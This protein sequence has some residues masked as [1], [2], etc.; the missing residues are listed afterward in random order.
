MSNEA[1]DSPLIS[2]VVPVKDEEGAVD[3]FLDHVLEE[4]SQIRRKHGS[5]FELIFVDDGSTDHTCDQVIRRRATSSSVPI[6]IISFSRNFGKEAAMTAGL[7]NAKGKAVVFMDVDLQDPVYLIEKFILKWNEGFDV[8]YAARVS[9][10]GDSF[11]KRA[12]ARMYRIIFNK[13][14]DISLPAGAGDYRLIDKRVGDALLLL[15]ERNRFM[16]GLFAWVGFRS[17]GVPFERTSRAQ[18]KSQWSY[19]KLW[20]FGL[21]GI[22]GFSHAPLRFWLYLGLAVFLFASVLASVVMVQKVFFGI[23]PTGYP[24]LMVALL[25]FGGLQLLAVGVI[26]EYVSRLLI[27]VKKRPLFV[28]DHTV[29]FDLTEAGAQQEDSGETKYAGSSD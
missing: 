19:K 24:S 12:T 13:I 29:G 10:P 17:V 18:G 28:I 5:Q 4:L 8:V 7:A 27:E 3:I 15:Q 6:K 14:S 25:F 26:G 16:K 21:D 23:T 22:V 20:N 11:V 1:T 9:R 2:I